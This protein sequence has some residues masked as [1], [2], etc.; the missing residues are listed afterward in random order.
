MRM[1]ATRLGM[2]TTDLAFLGLALFMN[3]F[4]AP[5]VKITQE[6]DGSYAYNKYSIYFVAEFI[7]LAVA[8]G[9]AAYTYTTEPE[10]RKLMVVT[11]RDVWQYAI[12]GFIFFVQNN[13]S[14][15]ALQHIS[16]AG[17]QL[18]LN[19]RIAAVGVLTVTLLGK[20]LN[21]LKWIAIGL[22]TVGSMQY[23][24]AGCSNDGGLKTDVE[25]LMVMGIL[26]TTAAAGNVVTQLVMQKNMDQPL[27]FQNM[28]LYSWG[29]IFNGINWFYSVSSSRATDK[30]VEWF[31]GGFGQAAVLL[32]VFNA[33]YGLSIS[34]ILK[35]FGSLPR[36]F[37]SC[38][39]IISNAFLDK[40]FFG[41]TMSILV[42]TTF[43]II[44]GGIYLF[45]IVGEEYGKL[46]EE[47]KSNADKAEDQQL[48]LK[49]N[50]ILD[51]G[52]EGPGSPRKD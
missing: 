41:E 20:K 46:E 15:I 29:V 37:I 32:C 25:G 19:M 16:N 51:N 26:I 38:M 44:L 31:G 17:F 11:T 27:M 40:I 4:T 52:D 10:V 18:L 1:P 28:L 12:P 33:I 14:F 48:T 7:K 43:A 13:L 22:L 30:P 24:L 5:A 2:S 34:V 6:E 8:G 9:W 45:T 21:K 47:K 36:T 50:N 49:I 23:E 42:L 35:R 3:T 39:A